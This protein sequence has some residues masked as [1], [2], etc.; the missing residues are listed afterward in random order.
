MPNSALPPHLQ[1]KKHN[2]WWWIFKHTPRG[3]TAF[4]WKMPPKLLIGY[5]VKRWDNAKAGDIGTVEYPFGK[6]WV[7]WK[8]KIA[9]SGA[10][11]YG[12]NAI[13]KILGQWRF[14][15]HIT[16]PLGIHF[17]I[18]LWKRNKPN[19]D[20]LKYGIAQGYDQTVIIYHRAGSRWDSFEAYHNC[21]SFFIGLTY[22]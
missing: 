22:N 3:W 21:P 10:E 14:S 20:D 12:P 6:G 18:K 19:K 9:I 11:Q 4:K 13:Q 1:G 5:N 15:F 7:T 16:W 8:N 17:T 2:D